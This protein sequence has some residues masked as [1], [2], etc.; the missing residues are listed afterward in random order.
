MDIKDGERI[1]TCPSFLTQSIVMIAVLCSLCLHGCDKFRGRTE[2]TASYRDT[3]TIPPT[4][5][6]QKSIEIN[7]KDL[8]TRLDEL[9]RQHDTRKD[10]IKGVMLRKIEFRATDSMR[11]SLAFIKGLQ[12]YL[13]SGN[14]QELLVARKPNHTAPA[15]D[16][17]KP[18][19]MNE[20]ISEYLMQDKLNF[21]IVNE[22]NQALSADFGLE[23][24]YELLVVA[25]RP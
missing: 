13:Q 9:A 14:M 4:A 12:L 19:L 6:G 3:L 1:A 25:G 16:L 7:I 8:P 23:L 15:E 2:F 10:L 21:R 22:L 24:Y 11:K 5:I 17:I 18:D 20:N